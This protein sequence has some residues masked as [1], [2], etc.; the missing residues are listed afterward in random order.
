M[1]KKLL[2]Y[3]MKAVWRVWWI[4]IPSLLGLSTF[5][6][7]SIRIF[8]ETATQESHHIFPL[9]LSFLSMFFMSIAYIGFFG[10]IVMTEILVFVRFYKNLFTD[11]GYLTFT[12]PVSRR[13]LLLSKVISGTAGMCASMGVCFVNVFM[14]NAIA[15]AS[16]EESISTE[17]LPTDTTVLEIL[18]GGVYVAEAVTAIVLAALCAVL[19]LYACITFASMIVKKGKLIVAIGIYYGAC[20][21]VYTTIFLFLL[22]VLN[23]ILGWMELIGM[24]AELWVT[25]LLWL[26]LIFF[27]GMICAILYTL[28]QLMLE[29]KLN[30][31]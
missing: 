22:F 6:A 20:N 7:M 26:V 27:L 15:Y 23:S 3:D 29:R 11:E 18:F 19:F 4:L 14:M 2:K 30:L 24:P 17:Y 8:I 13:Q 10:S 31:S 21:V 16:I 1:F 5:F 12:L 25:A 9:L 28:Q